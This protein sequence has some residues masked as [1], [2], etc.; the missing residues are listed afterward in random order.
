MNK[1]RKPFRIITCC[2]GESAISRKLTEMGVEFESR[3]T[4]T[5]GFHATEFRIYKPRGKGQT[6]KCRLIDEL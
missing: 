1:V 5:N 4:M 3:Y 6:E 2:H